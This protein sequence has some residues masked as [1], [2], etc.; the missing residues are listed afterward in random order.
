MTPVI[1]KLDSDGGVFAA[2]PA[3]AGNMNPQTMACYA[4]VGQH[5]TADS[6][7]V[8]DAKPAKPHEYVGLLV[9]LRS[10]GYDDLVIRRRLTRADYLARRNQVTP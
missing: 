8:R 10:I 7:Y 4:H 3:V 9:E 5:G 6:G 2:F 1:F